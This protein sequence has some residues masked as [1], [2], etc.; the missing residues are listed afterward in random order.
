M[1][2]ANGDRTT[3]F[4]IQVARNRG[5]LG[6]G[7]VPNLNSAAMTVITD[8]RDGRIQGWTEAPVLQVAP[9]AGG[10][11]AAESAGEA[12][13][14]LDRKEIVTKWAKEFSLEGLWGNGEDEEETGE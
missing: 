5:R 11:D 14:G 3:D 2:S 12:E 13:A 6:K 4:L 7:G 9:A 8:W 10:G 1:P